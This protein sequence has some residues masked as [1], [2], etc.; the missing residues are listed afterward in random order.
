MLKRLN[1]K[2]GPLGNRD[3]IMT[4]RIALHEDRMN[5][6]VWAAALLQLCL[7]IKGCTGRTRQARVSTTPTFFLHDLLLTKAFLF[8]RSR[9]LLSQSLTSSLSRTF[10]RFL[11]FSGHAE[12]DF[13]SFFYGGEIFRRGE[14][15]G[16]LQ[17]LSNKMQK[18]DY[19]DYSSISVNDAL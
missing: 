9:L 16:A 17:Q 1:L 6:Q 13:F 4:A 15:N 5:R 19:R 12:L 14:T 11:Y 18:N 8:M 2:E 7:R 10:S 3:R